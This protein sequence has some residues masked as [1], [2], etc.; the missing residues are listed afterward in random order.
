M[1]AKVTTPRTADAHNSTETQSPDTEAA[2]AALAYDA[3]FRS[4]VE[5]AVRK[6]DDPNAVW[7][8][9]EEVKRDFATRRAEWARKAK[10]KVSSQ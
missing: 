2:D 1:P 8:S 10:S 5:A 3:W 9:Q 7:I 4:E 6:A